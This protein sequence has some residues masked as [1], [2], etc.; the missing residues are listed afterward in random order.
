MARISCLS[1]LAAALFAAAVLSSVTTFVAPRAPMIRGRATALRAEGE[2]TA[3]VVITE[4]NKMTTASVLGGVVGLLVGGVWVGAALF[5]A[6]AF[7]ARKDEN[8]DVSKALKGVAATG[9][10]ALN[11]GAYLNDK[12]TVTDRIGGAF[13]DVLAEQSQGAKSYADGFVDAVQAADKDIN[14]KKTLGDLFTSASELASQAVDKAVA[15]NEE[16]KITDQIKEK[17]EEAT[18]KTNKA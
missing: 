16:Y 11:F 14:F 4:E 2:S 13:S 17:I 7:V 6:G 8:S 1:V 12:Y 18:S 10:E 9:L 15:I 5:A 3:L